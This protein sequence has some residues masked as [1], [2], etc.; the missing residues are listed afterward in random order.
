MQMKSGGVA[1]SADWLGGG[2]GEQEEK[3]SAEGRGRSL[4]L[5]LLLLP[6]LEA[7]RL[8]GRGRGW[9]A[10]VGASLPQ[11]HPWWCPRTSPLSPRVRGPR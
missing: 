2:G 7:G 5:L 6:G 3:R 10:A 11:E 8:R 4:V 1:R 9:E